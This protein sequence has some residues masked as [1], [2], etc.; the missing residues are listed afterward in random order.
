[1]SVLT[2]QPGGSVFQTL[3]LFKR[4]PSAEWL[5]SQFEN[6][7]FRA[8]AV[9]S[10]GRYAGLGFIKGEAPHHRTLDDIAHQISASRAKSHDSAALIPPLPIPVPLPAHI[11]G[12]LEIVFCLLRVALGRIDEF[13]EAVG[14]AS[15]GTNLA[16]AHMFGHT[17]HNVLL[18]VVGDDALDV[19]GT[20]R[21]LTS[22]P[23]IERRDV[24][25]TTAELTN[26]FGSS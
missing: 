12:D 5:T 7:R 10:S 13:F 2:S 21:A 26:G 24:L 14:E 3:V 17:G 20:V 9:L 15:T 19:F 23:E 1:M 6:E 25:R 22:G 8:T 4:L 18:E 11:P 16:G